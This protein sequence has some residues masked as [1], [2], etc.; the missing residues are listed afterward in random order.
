MPGWNPQGPSLRHCFE[1]RVHLVSLNKEKVLL[2]F[3]LVVFLCLLTA[4]VNA[5]VIAL[6]VVTATANAYGAAINTASDRS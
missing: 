6:A 1:I 3:L 5:F 2:L 4:L